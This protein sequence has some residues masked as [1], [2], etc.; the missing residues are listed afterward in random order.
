M[1]A[2]PTPT[3][4][5]MPFPLFPPHPGHQVDG[6]ICNMDLHTH[7][8]AHHDRSAYMSFLPCL[9]AQTHSLRCLLW[10]F[11]GYSS[12]PTT[13]AETVSLSAGF[14]SSFTNPST[15]CW[16]LFNIGEFNDTCSV[17]PPFLLP[18]PPLCHLLYFFKFLFIYLFFILLQMTNS[19]V[20]VE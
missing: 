10:G 16:V 6:S 5:P 13:Q 17:M 3:S 2:S 8:F 14:P 7:T 19:N 11:S 15:I 12:H 20:S 4:E 18:T 9:H 1:W